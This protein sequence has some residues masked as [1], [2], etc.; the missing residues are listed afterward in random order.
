MNPLLRDLLGHQLW[1][2]AELWTA[3][4]AHAPA[5]DDQVIHDRLHHI[6]EVQRAFVCADAERRR[7]PHVVPR[8]RRSNCLVLERPSLSVLADNM[9][10]AP[11]VKVAARPGWTRL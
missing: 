2:D 10:L 4:G 8:D 6:R 1:A 7:G 3:I 9:N 5:R 11:I